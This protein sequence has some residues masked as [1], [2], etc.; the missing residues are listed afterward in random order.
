MSI[1][2]FLQLKILKRNTP[3]ITYCKEQSSNTA[4]IS[5]KS[6][7]GSSPLKCHEVSEGKAGV[8]RHGTAALWRKGFLDPW[9]F[10]H[11]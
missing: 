4:S 7:N 6:L 9:T 8:V 1:T 5:R 11:P 2:S 3:D 10:I